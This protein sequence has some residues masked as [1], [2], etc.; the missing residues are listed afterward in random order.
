MNCG[1]RDLL[2]LTLAATA[3]SILFFAITWGLPITPR[4]PRSVI[5]MEWL[6]TG[7]LTAAVWVAYRLFLEKQTHPDRRSEEI[8]RVLVVGAG[9][10]GQMLV[11]EM[12]RVPTGYTVVGF[13]DDNRMKWGTLIH[14]VEVIGLVENLAAIAEEWEIEQIFTAIPSAEPAQL[15]RIIELCENFD[16]GDVTP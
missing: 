10:A 3:G 13:V 11:R 14:G 16:I 8:K 4:V 9:V 2:H 7:N 15:R 12:A 1:L 5:V 6:L